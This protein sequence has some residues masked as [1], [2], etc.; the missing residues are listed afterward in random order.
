MNLPLI[1]KD[2]YGDYNVEAFL[3]ET[4]SYMSLSYTILS[5]EGDDP[6]GNQ[7]IYEEGK[8]KRHFR[9]LCHYIA[10]GGFLPKELED[11]HK[12]GTLFHWGSSSY[13]WAENLFSA[14]DYDSCPEGASIIIKPNKK[15]GGFNKETKTL[16]AALV[17]QKKVSFHTEDSLYSDLVVSAEVGEDQVINYLKNIG[18]KIYEGWWKVTLLKGINLEV[19]YEDNKW[20]YR[21][22]GAESV[23]RNFHSINGQPIINQHKVILITLNYLVT[24]SNQNVFKG[25]KAF[26]SGVF[27]EPVT[28]GYSHAILDRGIANKLGTL[29]TYIGN[30]F[31]PIL[32]N[33]KDLLGPCQAFED[34]GYSVFFH[35]G[36]KYAIINAD[37][38]GFTRKEGKTRIPYHADKRSKFT[39]RVLCMVPTAAEYVDD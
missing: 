29:G 30:N 4:K 11:A 25:R 28:L 16:M 33:T 17:N 24:S 18:A 1:Q 23:V 14:L 22:G 36:G 12:G 27:I 34:L 35:K 39:G 6:T 3:A 8:G 2:E 37:C 31:F 19:K 13:P 5:Y 7:E 38:V 21:N 10:L 32:Y 20:S 9:N 15:D 26:L